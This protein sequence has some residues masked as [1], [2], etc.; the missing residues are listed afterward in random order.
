MPNFLS[1]IAAEGLETKLMQC[2]SNTA[3]LSPQGK[4]L[5]EWL[6]RSWQ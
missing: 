2:L 6:R 4:I 5:M 3:R 1:C